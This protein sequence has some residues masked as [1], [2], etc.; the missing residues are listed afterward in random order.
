MILR[1]AGRGPTGRRPEQAIR[2]TH[3]E[4]AEALSHVPFFSALSK[5]ELRHLAE[6]T[7]VVTF[8]AGQ[9]IVEEG[10]LG[11]TMYLVLAG[12]AKVQQG[13]RRLGSIRPGDFFGEVAV[14]DGSPRS[15]TVTAQTPLTAIRLYRHTLLGLFKAEPGIAL[16]VLDGVV[17][18]VRQLTSALDA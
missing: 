1:G 2:R 15:A 8:A 12:E 14:L 18:R 16:K 17:K 13:G 5:R 4:T 7:D 3:R 10:M 6:D 9:D 11:E